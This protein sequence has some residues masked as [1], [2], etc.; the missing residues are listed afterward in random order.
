M[1]SFPILQPLADEAVALAEKL[2]AL[3]DRRNLR[4]SGSVSGAGNQR[5]S[6]GWRPDR[7]S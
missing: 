4:G 3:G 7:K 2:N 6:P 5:D 1:S